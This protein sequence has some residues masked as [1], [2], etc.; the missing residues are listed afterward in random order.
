MRQE[1]QNILIQLIRTAVACENSM[2][3]RESKPCRLLLTGLM[4][5]SL[6]GVLAVVLFVPEA[7]A[8]DKLYAIYTAHSLS[9]VY[10]WIAQETG[11]FKKYDLEVPLVYVPA[12]AP[13]VATILTG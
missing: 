12:G 9:H 4:R 1:S 10:P 7:F 13:A 2:R 5:S 3:I 11:I 8:A 6:V